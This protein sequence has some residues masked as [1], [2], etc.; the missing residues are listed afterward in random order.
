MLNR[1][2]QAVNTANYSGIF[3]Y[4]HGRQT[5]A[6][7]IIH[8][9]GDG[10]QERL[11]SLTGTP[12]EVIRS[13]TTVTC[14]YP[15][16]QSVMVE[17]SRPR[18]Y[19][20]QLPEPIEQ[21][22]TAYA[23][24]VAGEDRV[25]G[26]ET[27]VV[28]IEARDAYRYGYRISIDKETYLPMRTELRTHSGSSVEE[29]MFTQIELPPWIPDVDL[30][31]GISGQGYTWFHESA[32]EDQPLSGDAQ[33]RATWMPEGFRVSHHERRALA[34]TGNFVD[35][36]S[37]SDGMSSVSVFVEPLRNGAP[38]A[39]SRR[40]G[41]INTYVRLIRGHQITAVGEVPPA[42]VQRMANSV[43]SR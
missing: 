43:V 6:M 15:E 1:M 25:A 23:I 19:V 12:R 18:R 42:T 13:G 10:E 30:Q 38:R 22:A 3:I 37:Y 20:V 32:A 2:A 27:W 36:I 17:T 7:R 39:G 35:H 8:R 29:V 24:D 21:L 34:N 4:R 28:E 41:G 5:D 33:W 16:S 40:I 26:R 9:G 31:P 11:I 14:I